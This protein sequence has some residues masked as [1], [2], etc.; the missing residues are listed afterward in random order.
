MK[1]RLTLLLVPLLAFLFVF[2]ACAPP[3]QEGPDT[4][5]QQQPSTPPNSQDEDGQIVEDT[6]GAWNTDDVDTS[7]IR[8]ER[9]VAFTFDDGPKQETQAL[10]EVFYEYNEDNPDWQAHATFFMLGA[11]LA[12]TDSALL[13]DAVEAGMELGNHA[14]SHANLTTIGEE[15]ARKE[16]DDTDRL[17]KA[18]DNKERHLLRPPGGHY[19][20]RLLSLAEV[21]LI[22][23]TGELDTSDWSGVSEN[24]IYN[25]VSSN[26]L[27]GG[28]VLMHQGYSTTVSAVRRL[29]PALKERGFQ[30]VSVSELAKAY[31]IDMLAGQAYSYLG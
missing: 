11:N 9:L 12:Q 23:W 14:Y 26:L 7:H 10:L 25:K 18:I 19:D 16:I 17:L 27:D 6:P 4:P 2:G 20:A 1:K 28:I 31:G 24:E 5:G 13:A 30:V 15:Q 29:L 3:A 21:P 22:N 8:S